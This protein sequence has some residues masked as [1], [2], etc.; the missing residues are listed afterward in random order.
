MIDLTLVIPTYQRP[1]ELK[2]KLYHLFLQKCSSQVVII[3]SSTGI[4]LKKN[5]L[6]I[7]EYKKKIKNCLLQGIN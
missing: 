6:T 4:K 5:Y 2:R 3:D 7:K 1:N